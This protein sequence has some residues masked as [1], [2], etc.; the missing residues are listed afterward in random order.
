MPILPTS[1]LTPD[2]HRHVE[3]FELAGCPSNGTVTLWKVIGETHDP[4]LNSNYQEQVVRFIKVHF[5]IVRWLKVV[6]FSLSLLRVY[7]PSSV[8]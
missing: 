8:F 2:S 4:S 1:K 7:H 6:P 5:T 3:V